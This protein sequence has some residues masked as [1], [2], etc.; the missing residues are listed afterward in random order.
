VIVDDDEVQLREQVEVA[1]RLS[2][3]ALLSGVTL[4]IEVSNSAYYVAERLVN[5]ATPPWDLVLADVFMPRPVIPGTRDVKCTAEARFFEVNGVEY[6][7]FFVHYTNSSVHH[8]D[9]GVHVARK[10]AEA[11]G[12]RRGLK[13]VLVSALFEDGK[14]REIQ[15][16]QLAYPGWF[17]CYHKPSAGFDA[18]TFALAIANAI[19][20]RQW[21]R[22]GDAA[23]SDLRLERFVCDSPAMESIDAFVRFYGQSSDV[24]AVWLTG[25]PGNGRRTLARLL[26]DKRQVTLNGSGHFVEFDSTQFSPETFQANLFGCYEHVFKVGPRLKDG[27]MQRAN[28]GTVYIPN[29]DSLELAPQKLL[30]ALLK[31]RRYTPVG[32]SESA[33]APLLVLST[34]EDHDQLRL[35]TQPPYPVFDQELLAQLAGCATVAIPPMSERPKDVEPIARLS[36]P[37]DMD[38]E[39]AAIGEYQS[40]HLPTVVDL[41]NC[42]QRAAQNVRLAGRAVVHRKDVREALAQVRPSETRS[43]VSQVAPEISKRRLRA[44]KK[45]SDDDLRAVRALAERYQVALGDFGR[46]SPATL[47]TGRLIALLED[48]ELAAPRVMLPVRAF[49]AFGLEK[50]VRREQTAVKVAYIVAVWRVFG[51]WRSY[52]RAREICRTDE[53]GPD[54]PAPPR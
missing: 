33:A 17:R 32:G 36:L 7:G 16:L 43:D 28:G 45:R 44:G 41:I 34:S 24:G 53:P 10:L 39:K 52:D 15:D 14:P 54:V 9:G 38:I 26:H 50:T 37:K 47:P 51:E 20:E 3:S 4:Q 6:N 48:A 27:A 40:A 42:M 8:L 18:P 46:Q 31:R 2:Q 30:A 35:R 19:R 21:A 29:V 5:A 1:A 11:G 22:F 23:F 49:D 13:V 12:P 25:L